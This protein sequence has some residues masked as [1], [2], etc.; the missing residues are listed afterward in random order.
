[1]L[2]LAA[3]PTYS[4]KKAD[5]DSTELNFKSIAN[6][7]PTVFLDEFTLP[8]LQL[9]LRST[10]NVLALAF[11]EPLDV[12]QACHTTVHDPNSPAFAITA[13]HPL[14]DFLDGSHVVSVSREHLVTDGESQASLTEELAL[15]RPQGFE[16]WTR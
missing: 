4:K 7:R 3:S 14:D 10:H 5:E 8:V 2:V 6:L 15:A 1:M 13:L 12:L 9:A 16:P 11:L